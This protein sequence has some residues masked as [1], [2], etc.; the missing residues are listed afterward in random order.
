MN[1]LIALVDIEHDLV[2]RHVDFGANV[3]LIVLGLFDLRARA[4]PGVDRHF[5]RCAE[6]AV[7]ARKSGE[8]FLV[9]VES[10]FRLLPLRNQIDFG[11]GF[12]LSLDLESP[13]PSSSIPCA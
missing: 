6:L 4:C 8:V 7:I 10:R 3:L 5:D 1:L 12:A 9:V 11:K 2:T 13:W